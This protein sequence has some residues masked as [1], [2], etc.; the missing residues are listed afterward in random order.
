MVKG[1]LDA[2]QGLLYKDDRDIQCLTSRRLEYS[3]AVGY[4][5]VSARP[6]VPVSDDIII[7]DPKPPVFA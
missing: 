5:R 6:V 3:G 7:D 4:Y 2:M 1:L